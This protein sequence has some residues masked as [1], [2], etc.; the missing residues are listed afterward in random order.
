MRQLRM[1]TS[2]TKKQ[3]THSDHHDLDDVADTWHKILSLSS[4]HLPKKKN[5]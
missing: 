4:P 3:T 1:Y 2:E 5:L